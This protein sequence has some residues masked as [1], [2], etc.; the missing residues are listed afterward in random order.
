M[1]RVHHESLRAIVREMVSAAG[2]RGD[3]PQRVADNLVYANLTGHDSHG[4]GMLPAYMESVSNGELNPNQHAEIIVDHGPVVVI[5]GKAG[6][7]QVI[8]VEAMEI[9]IERAREHGVCV[10]AIRGSFHLCRIGAWG[11]Q[12]AAAGMVSMHHVNGFGNRALVAPFRGTD[13]RY[14]TNPY[15]CALP[16]TD[17][18]PTF[19]ADFATSVIAMGKIRVAKNK[20][21]RLPNGIVFDGRGKPSNDPNVMYEQPQGAIRPLG[22]H[23]GYCLALINELVA[24]AL[25]GGKTWRPETR[26]ENSTILNNML[27][28]IIDPGRLTDSESFKSE[29]DAAIAHAKASPL[30]NPDEPVLIPGDPERHTMAQ[31]LADGIPI[32]AETWCQLLTAA[33]LAGMGA[34]RVEHLGSLSLE[35]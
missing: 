14:A 34:D 23:K 33:D 3:E 15:C 10:L 16:S 1:K 30:E 35:G 25:T 28:I 21:E 19:I 31:R 22:G 6:Y 8:G 4:V 17:N 2:S 7:G 13:A 26:H 24:G 29:V 32:D 18:N 20:G 12:C 9:G 11:E 27:T 5:D